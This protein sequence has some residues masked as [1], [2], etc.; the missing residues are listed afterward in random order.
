[1]ERPLTLDDL[2]ANGTM[3]PEI[4]A[5]LRATAR[6][7]H[8]FLVMAV[9]RFAGKTTVMRA[10]LAHAPAGAPIHTIGIDGDDVEALVRASRGGYL[11]VPEISRG[12]WAPGYIWGSRVRRA[13]AGI[14]EGSVLATALHAPDVDTAFTIICRGNGVPDE[15]AARLALVVYLRSLGNDLSAPDRRVVDS[16]HEIIAV[17]RGRP[18]ARLLQHWNESADRFEVLAAPERI[19]PNG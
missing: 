12:T 17:R 16:V 8:S 7:R 1:M 19:R 9:P 5:T 6:G 15:D 2:V 10:M 14:A 18:Q 11:V 13:F 4:G 3:S